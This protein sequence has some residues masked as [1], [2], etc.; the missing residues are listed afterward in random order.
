M[1]TVAAAAAAAGTVSLAWRAPSWPGRLSLF[2]FGTGL[3]ALFATSS[4]YHS[5]PWRR[6]WRRRMQQLD[7]SMIFVLIAAS[8]TPISVIVLDGWLTWVT[9]V[10]VWGTAL[11]GILLG[12]IP[13]GAKPEVRAPISCLTLSIL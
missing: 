3:I 1:N 11:T 6:I 12:I 13:D 8:Y 9:I 2:V 10:V 7:H 4:L 5:V